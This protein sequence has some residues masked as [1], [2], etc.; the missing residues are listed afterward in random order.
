MRAKDKEKPITGKAVK[1]INFEKL[2]LM[3][4]ESRARELGASVSQ[5]CNQ[6]VRDVVLSDPAYHKSMS[7]YYFMKGQEHVSLKDQAEARREV[8]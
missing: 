4:L 7:K 1:A 3:K 5:L 6:I 8:K 2:V